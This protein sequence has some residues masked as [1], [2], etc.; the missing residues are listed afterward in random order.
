MTK[1]ISGSARPG[2]RMKTTPQEPEEEKAEERKAV[3]IGGGRT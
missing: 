2:G 1:S 3:G